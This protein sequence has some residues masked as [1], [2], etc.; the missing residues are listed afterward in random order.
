MTCEQTKGI[1]TSAA[2]GK[3][4][5]QETQGRLGVLFFLPR[6]SAGAE[7]GV[8][9]GVFSRMLL[10]VAK[11]TRLFLVDPWRWQEPNH[12]VRWPKA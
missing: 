9:Q 4:V 3:L 8:W 11:P 1:W 2:R 5:L 12:D 6:R 7:I 10:E